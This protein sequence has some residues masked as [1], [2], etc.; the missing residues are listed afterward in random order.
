MK[1]HFLVLCL[2]VVGVLLLSSRESAAT[3]ARP[4]IRPPPLT[5][6]KFKDRVPLQE[7]NCNLDPALVAEIKGY[8]FIANLIITTVVNGPLRGKAYDELA[9]FVDKHVN[10]LTGTQELEDS[11]D[12][13]ME[14]MVA[15]GLVNV[16]GEPCQVPRWIR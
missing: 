16:R 3:V 9:K 4:I 12:Y 10:R 6:F 8:E 14:K 15:D 1:G 7:P 13:M 2:E 5:T 11:I